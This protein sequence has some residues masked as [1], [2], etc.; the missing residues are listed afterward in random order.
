MSDDK[1]DKNVVELK[2]VAKKEET[3]EDMMQEFL[4]NWPLHKA[5]MAFVAKTRKATYDA[6]VAEGFSPEQAIELCKGSF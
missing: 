6:L 3:T 5:Q 2:S 4:D 1:D